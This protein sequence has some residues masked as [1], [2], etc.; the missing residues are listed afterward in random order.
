MSYDALKTSSRLAGDALVSYLYTGQD[1]L[2][3]WEDR[4]Q[5]PLDR[6]LRELKTQ[7]EIYAIARK[8]ERSQ[9]EDQSVAVPMPEEVAVPVPDE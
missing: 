9:L 7:F 3:K 8:L 5:S 2:L 6:R 1:K 4:R